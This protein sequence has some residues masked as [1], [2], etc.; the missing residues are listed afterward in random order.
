MELRG[1][2]HVTAMT[3]SAEKIYDFFTHI[4][5][6]RLV[7]KTV[8]QDDIDTYHLFFADDKG[9][10]GTDMTFFDFKGIRKARFGNNEIS[11][12][13]FRVP[14]DKALTYW[15]KRLEHYQVKHSD[16]KTIF[17]RKVIY[18]SDFDDQRYALFSDQEN[19]GIASGEPWL[20][21]PVPNEFAITG[22][23][24]V[25]ITVNDLDYMDK[26]LTNILKMRKTSKEGSLY[27]Y[28][29]GEGGNGGMVIIEE[30]KI[31]PDAMQG[32]GGVHHVAFRVSDQEELLTWDKALKM[33]QAR[34]SGLV[35]RFY[36]ES[37]YTRM[38]PNVLFELATDG[39][40]FIDDEENYET[41]GEKLALPP[42]YRN[43]RTYVES[44][45][46]PIDTIRSNK[47]YDKEYF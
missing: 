2:H 9:N 22:L 3:S 12:T 39:P 1:I 37:V 19:N 29:M 4:L 20:K 28:E 47:T 18:F 43:Q 27:S 17:Q 38:Y 44:V 35:D 26:I 7:K 34:T 24:P 6:L 41:L 23:G 10:P 5:G 25:Y 13:G 32:Y 21:G 40:G 46:R 15:K 33:Y 14:D 11:R 45:V 36:F 30:S 31:L 42:K 16:I 8:N